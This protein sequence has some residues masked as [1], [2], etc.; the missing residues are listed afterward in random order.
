M[1]V[2]VYFSDWFY[3]LIF[4]FHWLAM[5]GISVCFRYNLVASSPED[6]GLFRNLSFKYIVFDE[7]HMLKNMMSKRYSNLTRLR[8]SP[9]L[10]YFS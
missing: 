2:I 4:C 9:A 1:V 6:K 5:I 10:C 8:V 3:L 7:A